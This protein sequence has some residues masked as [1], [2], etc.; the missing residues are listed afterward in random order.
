MSLS[1]ILAGPDGP[2]DDPK[3]WIC[4]E[5]DRPLTDGNSKYWA[6]PVF[7]LEGVMAPLGA[8]D[9]RRYWRFCNTVCVIKNLMK[10]IPEEDRSL[11]MD[12]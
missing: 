6:F 12:G 8:E 1:E 2:D 4:S 11:L 7:F 3:E 10:E 5:C 9:S